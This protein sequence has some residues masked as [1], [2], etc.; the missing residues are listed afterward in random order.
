LVDAAGLAQVIGWLVSSR[1][2]RWVGLAAIGAAA[3]KLFAFLVARNAKLKQ[4]LES[5]EA[6]NE[7]QKDMR[8]AAGR[9]STAKP[10]VVERL[11]DADF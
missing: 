8:E 11:R 4:R 3:L 9:T 6:A 10:D 1:V 7:L 5:A 2:G